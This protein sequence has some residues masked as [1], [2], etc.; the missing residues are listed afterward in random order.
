MFGIFKR[1]TPKKALEKT[2]TALKNK[3][4]EST[5]SIEP[6]FSSEEIRIVTRMKLF[7]NIDARY[8]GYHLSGYGGFG[9]F[10]HKFLETVIERIEHKRYLN[11]SIQMTAY[12]LSFHAIAL[13]GLIPSAD[14]NK[15]DIKQITDAAV[16]A[17]RYFELT[18][19]EIP[20]VL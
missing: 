17:K 10:I 19:K 8:K 16:N 6:F 1:T 3:Y 12:K 14:L 11:T 4:P 20:D 13:A 15:N 18:N 5:F 7:K 2:T 9:W